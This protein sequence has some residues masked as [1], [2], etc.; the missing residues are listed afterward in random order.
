MPL[1]RVAEPFDH[2][3]W[4][5][6][7]KHDGLRALAYVDRY[8]CTLLSRRRHIYKQF[9]M[10]ATELAH[11]V[12]ARSC[13]LDGEIV[14]LGP[15]GRSKFYDLLFRREWPHF[16]AFDALMINGE[17]LRDRPLLERKRRLR[18]IMPREAVHARVLY[19]D[20]VDGRGVDLFAAIRGNDLEGVVAKWRYGRYHTDGQTTSWFKIRNPQYSQVD[21]RRD[22]FA[23]RRSAWSRSRLAKPVLCAELQP[24]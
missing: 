13:V 7:L 14:A 19:H 16:I 20:Y 1:I 12:R 3:D 23:P 6:E 24:R 10:L 2:P 21:G 18:A 15:D 11:A 17:D 4:I 22:V 9:P 8:E 5:F